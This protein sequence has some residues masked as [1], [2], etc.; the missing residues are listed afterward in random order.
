VDISEADPR[1]ERPPAGVEPSEW[2][3]QNIDETM[4]AE[5]LQ[6]SPTF[7]LAYRW[8]ERNAPK[9]SKLAVCHR[10]FRNGNLIIGPDGLRAS[11]DWEG[12]R[13]GD[14]MEDPPYMC[15]RMWRFRNDDLEV[16]GFA[17][18]GPLRDGYKAAGGDWNED[19]FFWWKVMSTLRWGVGLNGQARQHLD[20]SVPSIVMA[21]SGR[22]VAEQE[23]DLLML[24][25]K[26]FR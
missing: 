15:Q 7:T 25:Q 16:G 20:G 13:V 10:D 22:R 2:A 19:S 24:L 18:R 14:P 21:G 17:Q 12:S 11:L 9:A 26:Q 6:P 8:L 1:M 4:S 23:Y 3:L 5:L